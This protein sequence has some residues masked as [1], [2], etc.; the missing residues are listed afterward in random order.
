MRYPG[1]I[2]PLVAGLIAGL[3]VGTS[4]ALAQ[5]EPGVPNA[6][7]PPANAMPAPAMS[8]NDRRFDILEYVV[9][10]NTV[11][12]VPDVEEAVYPFLGEGRS[13]ADVDMARE[14]LEQVY[15]SKGYQTVQ[16]A[17]PQQGIESGIIHLQV[18]ENPVGRLRVVDSQIP[19]AGTDPKERA[20]C[21]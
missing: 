21:R 19:L 8:P 4:Y 1:I 6:D 7:M 13:A 15:R 18:V 14:A 2:R 5:T 12:S 17:I 9:D 10:G 11:L 20:V 3:S 16:V